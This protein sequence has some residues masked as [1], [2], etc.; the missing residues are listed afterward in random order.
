MA[1]TKLWYDECLVT[2]TQRGGSDTQYAC[3]TGDISINGGAATWEM[4]NT[5]CGQIGRPNRQEPFE[6]VFDNAMP[7]FANDFRQFKEGGSDTTDPIEVTSGTKTDNKYRLALLWTSDRTGSGAT[8]AVGTGSEALRVI[9]KDAYFTSMEEKWTVG[10]SLLG[11]ITFW[12]P[13]LDSTGGGNVKWQSVSGG[14]SMSAL[15]AYTGGNF[16]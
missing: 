8:A 1:Q 15:A 10:E 11:N 2:I 4:I 12:V 13:A 14:T 9:V 7:V 3:K 16:G 6:I 5:N